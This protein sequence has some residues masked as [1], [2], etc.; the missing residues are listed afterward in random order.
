MKN[1]VVAIRPAQDNSGPAHNPSLFDIYFNPY[2][3]KPHLLALQLL[4]RNVKTDKCSFTDKH[5][6]IPTNDLEIATGF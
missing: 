2:T 6:K 4:S 1:C 3:A 5:T